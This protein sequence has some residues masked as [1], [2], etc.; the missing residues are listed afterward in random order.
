MNDIDSSAI[1]RELEKISAS[2]VFANSPRMTRFL[3]FVV[4]ET[5]AGNGGRIK[6]YVIAI[7]VFDK[8]SDFDP[9]ADSTVRTEASKLRSRL[10]RYYEGEGQKDAVLISIPKG[11]YVPV[12]EHR[13]TGASVSPSKTIPWVRVAGIVLSAGVLLAGFRIWQVGRQPQSTPKLTPITSFAELEEQPSLSP[14]GSHVA[15]SWK[16]DIYVKEVTGEGLTQVT[17][18]PA[19]DRA[20]AWSPDGRDIAFVRQ[21]VRPIGSILQGEVFLISPLGGSERRIAES[22]GRPSWMPDSSAIVVP[23]RTSRYARS[24]F[25]ISRATSEKRQLTFPPDRSPGDA[26]GAVSPDGR[27]L[28]FHR[29]APNDLY[30]VALAGGKPHQLTN[31][32]APILGLTWTRDSSELI[33]S[34]RRTDWPRLWRVPVRPEGSSGSVPAPVPVNGAGDD[35]RFPTLSKSGSRLAYERYTRNFDIRRAELTGVE[36]SPTHSLKPSIPFIPSSRQEF[37][38]SFSPDGKRIAFVSDRSGFREIWT[39]EI[40]GTNQ[41]KITSFGGPAV[42]YPRWFP[43]SQR[44]IFSASTGRGGGVESYTIAAGG[45]MPQRITTSDARTMAHPIVSRDGK[46]IYFIPGAMDRSVDIW[47]IPLSG[48]PVVQITRNEASHPQESPEGVLYYGKYGEKGLWSIPV[49]GGAERQVLDSNTGQNWTVA[50]KGIYFIDFDVPQGAPK[51]LKFYSFATSQVKQVGTV[52]PTVSSDFPG[53]AVS[54]D[55]RW[56]LYSHIASTTADLMLLD[57]LR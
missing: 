42:S 17:K 1:R 46:W 2:P 44:L 3:D 53:I 8:K 20:P 31:D 23:L 41:L 32:K 39:C 12:F 56:L 52:E 11:T 33:F 13:S 4:R 45:G 7:E 18:D 24:I 38:P 51:V 28:A 26:Y 37:E 6:E 48:G 29:V 10:N 34:S 55:G 30:V 47:R 43:N 22:A 5:L 21:D 27:T 57:G 19:M 9:Q 16:G 36:G 49:G 15:F 50:R 35:A 25:S 14:D 54:P 40:D